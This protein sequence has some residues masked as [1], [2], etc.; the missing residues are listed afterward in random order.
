MHGLLLLA[1]A[2]ALL[3]VARSTRERMEP[4][5]TGT[6]AQTGGTGTTAQTGSTGTSSPPG[7]TGGGAEEVWT[8]ATAGGP[9]RFPVPKALVSLVTRYES[10]YGAAETNRIVALSSL[11]KSVVDNGYAGVVP[12]DG[13]TKDQIV[14]RFLTMIVARFY[15]SVYKSSTVPITIDIIRDYVDSTYASSSEP[16]KRAY[17]DLL[18]RYYLPSGTVERTEATFTELD[19]NADQ[20]LN[21]AEFG[22]VTT[23][24]VLN[25]LT[26]TG[27]TG[28]ADGTETLTEFERSLREYQTAEARYRLTG[29]PS[30]KTQ[31]DG[32]KTWVE[33]QIQDVRG[34]V[35][36]NA[37]YIKEFV[38]KYETSD[39]DL[40]VMQSNLRTIRQTGPQVQAQYETETESQKQ[41]PL[42]FTR[43]YP[44]VTAITALLA[45]AIGLSFFT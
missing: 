43:F 4:G 37:D 26:G 23:P 30:Y 19:T 24:T 34:A 39:N 17:K 7:A 16:N 2:L 41:D 38:H 13:V 27:G 10:P 29:M 25:E 35:T 11:A 5:A 12:P 44:K 3:F 42:D 6:T 28:A 32:W 14:A 15:E 45:G 31:A 1:I 8:P 36:E 20:A 9:G 40:Q 21:L 18:R 22:Q 33:R